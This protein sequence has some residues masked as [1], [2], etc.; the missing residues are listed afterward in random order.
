ML[1][2]A[3]FCIE[4][5]TSTLVVSCSFFSIF[6]NVFLFLQTTYPKGTVFRVGLF[7][8]M[9]I[10]ILA[11]AVFAGMYINVGTDPWVIVE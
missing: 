4:C 2:N 10:V 6:E 5:S 1:L 3:K 11:V 9:F 8:G 7:L